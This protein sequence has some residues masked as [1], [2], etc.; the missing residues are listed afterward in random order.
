MRAQSLQSWGFRVTGTLM[1]ADS[2]GLEEGAQGGL[3]VEREESV[4]EQDRSTSHETEEEEWEL[5]G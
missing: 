5:Q 2:E 4:P 1:A 3:F